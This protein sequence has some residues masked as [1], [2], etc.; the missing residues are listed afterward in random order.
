MKK[1]LLLVLL[2]TNFFSHAQYTAIPDVNFEK[3]LIEMGFD[4]IIDKRVATANIR[5]ISAISL[6]DLNIS[7][8]TGIQD[9]TSLTYLSC[10]G[11]LFTTLDISKN[12][13]L[14]EFGCI[15][16]KLTNIDF[17]NNLSLTK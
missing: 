14:T 6:H 5:N 11:N 15:G 4:D 9:F 12:T 1:S 17:S 16:S 7:D 13:A 10:G 3:A 8:L 2:I